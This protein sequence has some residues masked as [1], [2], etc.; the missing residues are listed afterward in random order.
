M[1]QSWLAAAGNRALLSLTT[2]PNFGD[3]INVV[4]ITIAT[5][6]TAG[7]VAATSGF[8]DPI[9]DF[10]P[11]WRRRCDDND[12]GS[13]CRYFSHW[14]IKPIS[15]FF[16]PSLA[17]EFFWRGILIA[18][19]PSVIIASTEGIFSSPMLLRR[20]GLVL[21]IHVLVHPLAGYTCWPRGRKMFCDWRFLVPATIVLGGATLSY[22]VSGGSV[23]AAALTHG[24]PVALW[25]DFFGGEA[26]LMKS[27]TENEND[28]NSGEKT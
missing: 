28:N 1:T 6:A 9:E 22:L 3:S 12:N 27:K 21:G 11:P 16:F 5:T 23:W 20:A 8:V 7:L 10:D 17:E 4:I 19:H 25:R 15:A 13:C 2:F 14:S 18:P 24:L 26:L